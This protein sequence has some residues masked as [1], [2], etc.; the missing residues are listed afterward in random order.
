[1]QPLRRG[2]AVAAIGAIAATGV[3]LAVYSRNMNRAY[4][5]SGEPRK[6]FTGPVFTS[7]PL[8]ESETVNHNTK[9]LRFQLP[10]GTVSGFPTTCKSGIVWSNCIKLFC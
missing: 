4:A 7:L 2:R 10:E 5:D 3:G 6:M 9:R 8:A 1:M